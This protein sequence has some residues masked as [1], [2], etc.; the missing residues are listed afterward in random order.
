MGYRLNRLDEFV[1]VAGPKTL[2]TQFGMHHRLESCGIFTNGNLFSMK[3]SKL[4]C[5]SGGLLRVRRFD[6]T[7]TTTNSKVTAPS[8]GRVMSKD[9]GVNLATA[10]YHSSSPVSTMQCIYNQP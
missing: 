4:S 3:P 8:R 9:S 5:Y 2:T 7:S 1:F 10:T 6:A